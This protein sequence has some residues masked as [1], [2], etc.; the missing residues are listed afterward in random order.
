MAN[1]EGPVIVLPHFLAGGLHGAKDV[2]ELLGLPVADEGW[3]VVA[4]QEIGYGEPLGR[5][6]EMEELILGLATGR[7]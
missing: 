3:H 2:P 5:P 7:G 1:P 4:D 6:E